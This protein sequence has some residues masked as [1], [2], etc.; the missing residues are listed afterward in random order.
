MPKR[1]MVN[2]LTSCKPVFTEH[3]HK[4][5]SEIGVYTSVT[6]LLHKLSQPFD[7]H[8]IAVKYV[9]ARTEALLINQLSSKYNIPTSSVKDM[10]DCYGAVEAVKLVW[11]ME[12]E[13]ACTDGT[14]V[15]LQKE[16]LLRGKKEFKL[17]SGNMVPLGV[18]HLHVL[19][20]YQLP[21][22]VYPELLIWNNYLMISGQSDVVVI[23]TIDGVRY[24]DIID[25][26]TNK[27]IKDY[28][29]ISK[30]GEKVINSMM[31]APLQN[32]CD[33]NY[34]HYQFQLNIYG[35][36]LAQFGF[37]FRSGTII[38]TTDNNKK[39]PLL[40]LQK[41]V[42]SLMRYIEGTR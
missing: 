33:C 12:N 6:T 17:K 29:Y 32:Y 11:K 28:N 39:Y 27:E 30:R 41:E 31:K 37:V 23:E 25:Y 14:A 5:Q 15:H 24:V 36:L 7:S 1:K 18:P 13:R 4:Y 38:H 20:L 2:S 34:W 3:D 35:W 21:D 42:G 10:I 9:S 16:N 40:N 19:D 22:G 26:K 8:A